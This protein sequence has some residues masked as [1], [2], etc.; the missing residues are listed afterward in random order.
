MSSLSWFVLGCVLF[1]GAFVGWHGR[2]FTDWVRLRGVRSPI[3]RQ[4]TQGLSQEEKV[5]NLSSLW[6]EFNQSRTRCG[7]ESR[8][9]R[10]LEIKQEF[11]DFCQARGYNITTE[12]EEFVIQKLRGAG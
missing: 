6:E 3:P 4:K 5:L 12:I 10:V 2:A 11:F 8:A 1:V 9:Y 7:D